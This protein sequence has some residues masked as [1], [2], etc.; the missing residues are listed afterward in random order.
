MKYRQ[1]GKLDWKASALGF[2]AMRLPTLGDRSKIDEDLAIRMIRYAID[3][4]VN[5]VDTAY[6]YHD[7]NSEL[8]VGK[9]LKDGYRKKV[10][11]ATKMPMHQ[12]QTREDLDRI[13]VFPDAATQRLVQAAGNR[14]VR[15]EQVVHRPPSH[16]QVKCY[17]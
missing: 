16:I 17:P 2:G 3:N 12:V 15:P 8:V 14:H 7:G 6:R 11:L 4:G 9:T 5:Y 1:F 10:R 13:A